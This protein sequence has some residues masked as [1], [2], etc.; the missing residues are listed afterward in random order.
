M[1][2]GQHMTCNENKL[3]I[4][5]KGTKMEHTT[6]IGFILGPNVR[7]SDENA[8]IKEINRKMILDDGIDEIKKG[9]HLWKR[10][11]IKGFVNSCHVITFKENRRNIDRA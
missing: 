6:K 9:I 3:K 1:N 4:M 11:K 2:Q 5:S 10:H 7:L 8:H